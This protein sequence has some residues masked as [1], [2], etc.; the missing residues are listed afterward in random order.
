MTVL[1]VNYFMLLT[2]NLSFIIRCIIP[3]WFVPE[4]MLSFPFQ[5]MYFPFR[6]RTRAFSVP[7]HVL[8]FPSQ[9]K[10]FLFR[11]RTWA[12]F[13][14][15]EHEL[16]AGSA[17]MEAELILPVNPQEKQNKKLK[18]LLA[19]NFQNAVLWY[20]DRHQYCFILPWLVVYGFLTAAV[21]VLAVPLAALA[22][23]K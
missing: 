23:T 12:Y 2:H 21:L 14:V 4:H 16:P 7:E 17:N 1:L 13:S 3:I 9:N 20:R 19:F 15:P 10:C 11:S 5:N 8:S 22:I 6:F 18:F